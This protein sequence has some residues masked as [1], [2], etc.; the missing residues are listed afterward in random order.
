M[1]HE[2]PNL[3]KSDCALAW[4]DGRH[5]SH[6]K[7]SDRVAAEARASELERQIWATQI[8]EA[9]GL[10]RAVLRE[11]PG[12]AEANRLLE[13]TVSSRRQQLRLYADKLE[14]LEELARSSDGVVGALTQQV[15][16]YRLGRA[17][18]GLS[19]ACR[20]V[21]SGRAPAFLARLE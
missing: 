11:R 16:S 8:A 7:H 1:P 20:R 17:L 12:R 4:R 21:W 5:R 6:A 2:L 3:N 15:S 10:L 9:E 13:A 19:R 14:G 18:L